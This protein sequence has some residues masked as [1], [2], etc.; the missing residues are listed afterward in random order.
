MATTTVDVANAMANTLKSIQY[1]CEEAESEYPVIPGNI[2][3]VLDVDFA[4]G[5]Q[6]EVEL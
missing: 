6:E 1:H 2:T 5:A 3:V 4:G